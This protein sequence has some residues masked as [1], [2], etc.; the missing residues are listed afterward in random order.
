MGAL[1]VRA[2]QRIRW[3]MDEMESWLVEL[4]EGTI[5]LPPRIVSYDW[6]RLPTEEEVS[7]ATGA[8]V[9]LEILGAGGSLV[10]SRQALTETAGFRLG[11]RVGLDTT[12]TTRETTELCVTVPD[13]VPVPIAS[14]LRSETVDL[15]AA[16]F[17]MIAGA[18]RRIV[19]ASPFWDRLTVGELGE[20]LG[21]RIEAG[22]QVDLLARLE[23]E[24]SEDYLALI[25][26]LALNGRVRLFRWYEPGNHGD[27]PIQTFHF[28]A[29]CI[30][31]GV[32]GYL[33]SANMTMTG[34]R[35]RLELGVILQGGPAV[36]LARILDTVLA[37]AT[38]VEFR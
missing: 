12:R 22:V 4:P 1:Y 8:L 13:A 25:D 3:L 2:V 23:S 34:L 26:T 20:L 21:R 17:T 18:H 30:D 10:L 19:L 27:R 11:V 16:L 31:D 24:T 29:A 6:S 36:A 9:D 7:I 38:Q 33:G 32:Q 5:V 28:K 14:I 37:V 35:S 15:R